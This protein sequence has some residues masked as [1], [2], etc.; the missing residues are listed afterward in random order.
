MIRKEHLHQEKKSIPVTNH[1]LSTCME[2]LF[3]NTNVMNYHLKEP[4]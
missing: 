1:H 3:Q 2:T 4:K